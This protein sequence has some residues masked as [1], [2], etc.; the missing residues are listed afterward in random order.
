MADFDTAREFVDYLRLSNERWGDDLSI[1]STWVFRGQADAAWPLLPTAWRDRSINKLEPLLKRYEELVPA[2]DNANERMSSVWS[3]AEQHAIEDFIIAAENHGVDTTL[4]PRGHYRILR[5]RESRSKMNFDSGN[6]MV[7]D[8]AAALAQHHGVP[9][10]VMDWSE[11]S[12]T[13]SFFAA[14]DDAIDAATDKRLTVVALDLS[15]I[16]HSPSAPMHPFVQLKP[17]IRSKNDFLRVQ[18]GLLTE[19]VGGDIY[20]AEHGRWPTLNI[21]LDQNGL[22][23]A[24]EMVTLPH[25]QAAELNAILRREGITKSLLMPTLDNVALDVIQNWGGD[26]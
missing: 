23:D 9:T 11:N 4:S 5:S 26:A 24:M 18:S 2:N 17:P 13:S 19:I 16:E 25:S 20:Y 22:S 10:R 7:H 14:N 12:M 3:I 21:A 1:P 8:T 6:A 15:R